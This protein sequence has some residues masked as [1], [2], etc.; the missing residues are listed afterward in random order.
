MLTI[1]TEDNSDASPRAE[2]V[3][4]V[5]VPVQCLVK[6]SKLLLQGSSKVCNCFIGIPK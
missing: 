6:G 4:D 1:T 3:I 5:T 2:D